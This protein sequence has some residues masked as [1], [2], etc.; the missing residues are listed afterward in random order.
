M[1]R[2]RDA[3]CLSE[4]RKL[5]GCVNTTNV[6]FGGVARQE[7]VTSNALYDC[8]AQ[9]VIYFQGEGKKAA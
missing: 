6:S 4:P 2:S 8:T 7:S 9:V 5:L 3:V 1:K